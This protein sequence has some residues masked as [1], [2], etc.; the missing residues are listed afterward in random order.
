MDDVRRPPDVDE[1]IHVFVIGVEYRCAWP[2]EFG[3]W[4]RRSLSSPAFLLF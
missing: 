2:F 1:A 3:T 4:P